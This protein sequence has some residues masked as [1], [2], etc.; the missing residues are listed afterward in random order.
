MTDSLE[1][2]WM[3]QNRCHCLV[4]VVILRSY[5]QTAF[6]CVFV[7]TQLMQEPTTSFSVEITLAAGSHVSYAGIANILYYD[8]S[9]G[10]TYN[11][12]GGWNRPYYTDPGQIPDHNSEQRNGASVLVPGFIAAVSAASEKYGL[13]PLSKLLEPALYFAAKGFKLPAHLA[14]DMRNNYNPSN[15]L[16][17]K[18]G[19]K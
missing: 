2:I 7:K 13:L 15:L 18:E 17:T 3:I 5:S 1:T 10:D 6:V 4:T 12:D 9:T 11:I 19:T 16:R 14:K 8:S